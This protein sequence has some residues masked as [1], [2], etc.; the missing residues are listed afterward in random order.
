MKLVFLVLNK[1]CCAGPLVSSVPSLAPSRLGVSPGWL[2][3]GTL[4]SRRALAPVGCVCVLV[5][6]LIEHSRTATAANAVR[7]GA[8]PDL[9]DP[10]LRRH[11]K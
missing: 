10:A 2:A 8:D 5:R 11:K 4:P 6:A 7:V 3:A 1:S 9:F